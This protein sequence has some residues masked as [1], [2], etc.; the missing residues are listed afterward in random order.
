[1][2]CEIFVLLEELGFVA[3]ALN[4][5]CSEELIC[6]RV[7]SAQ[8]L[9]SLWEPLPSLGACFQGPFSF[10]LHDW[11]SLCWH[12]A[13]RKEEV[14]VDKG[15]ELWRG[16]APCSLECGGT[17]EIL[18]AWMS[19]VCRISDGGRCIKWRRNQGFRKS[20]FLKL[21]E[22][23]EPLWDLKERPLMC[24]DVLNIVPQNLLP[25]VLLLNHPF[26]LCLGKPRVSEGHEESLAFWVGSDK[27]HPMVNSH[28]EWNGSLYIL[29]YGY[30]GS[31]FLLQICHWF[32]C[33]YRV[34]PL[35]SVDAEPT[36]TEYQL[37]CAIFY[38]EGTW[39]SV[40]FVSVWMYRCQCV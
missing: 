38:V 8:Y 14:T 5:V 12:K 40:D 22:I 31:F 30:W 26:H 17:Q 9:E 32:T 29:R 20:Q 35:V 36:N 1:M 7:E 28:S 23:R 10:L 6:S 37:H 25:S 13:Q 19:A 34:N 15:E 4:R 27:A 39:M 3:E 33:E 11:Q 16:A 18:F 2:N 21:I 24:T